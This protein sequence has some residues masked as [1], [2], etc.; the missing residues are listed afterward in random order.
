MNINTQ[1]CNTMSMGKNLK[2]ILL[3]QK[4]VK[5]SNFKFKLI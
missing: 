5:T 4:S 1:K 2:D 3:A